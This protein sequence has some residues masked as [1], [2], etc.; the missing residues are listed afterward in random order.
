MGHGD[1]R[2]RELSPYIDILRTPSLVDWT[3]IRFGEL[4]AALPAEETF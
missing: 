4:A 3:R 2:C 1:K